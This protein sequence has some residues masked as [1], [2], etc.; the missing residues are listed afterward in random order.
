MSQ[1]QKEWKE[2]R[3]Q[4]KKELWPS[5]ISPSGSVTQCLGQPTAVF[6]FPHW[7][8]E[9]QNQ[10]SCTK[11]TSTAGYKRVHSSCT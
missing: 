11:T 9:I 1:G 4:L 8:A 3:K 6:I 2:R 7:R 10:D 5:C